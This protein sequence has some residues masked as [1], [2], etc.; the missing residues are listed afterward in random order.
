MNELLVVPC[1]LYGV[2]Y[3]Q[4]DD[5]MKPKTGSPPR[6]CSG[7]HRRW[8]PELRAWRPS[9]SCMCTDLGSRSRT[10]GLGHHAYSCAYAYVYV[11]V[12]AHVWSSDHEFNEISS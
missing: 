12:Y 1:Q 2:T 10:S 11:Y 5:A 4:V 8:L 9:G 7:M 6:V 3:T